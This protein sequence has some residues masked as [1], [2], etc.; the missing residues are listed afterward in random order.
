MIFKI[1]SAGK[2]GR[3]VRLVF[4]VD[5]EAFFAPRGTGRKEAA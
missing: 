2:P 1:A 3:A 4:P 5:P